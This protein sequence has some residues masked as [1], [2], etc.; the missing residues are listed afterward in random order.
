MT[1]T[2][3]ARLRVVLMDSNDGPAIDDS[4]R[5][6]CNNDNKTIQRD[7]L[8]EQS[9]LKEQEVSEKHN[10]WKLIGKI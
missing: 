3:S 8:C 7:P 5:S 6:S 10:S 1:H 4:I 9:E 2:V